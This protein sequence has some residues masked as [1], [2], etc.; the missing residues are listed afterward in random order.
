M[1]LRTREELGDFALWVRVVVQ[2]GGLREQGGFELVL[3]QRLD[4]ASSVRV[5]L[6]A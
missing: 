5:K 3:L 4:T 1:A 2:C 6:E